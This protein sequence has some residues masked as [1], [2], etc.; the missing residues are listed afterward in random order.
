MLSE[1]ATRQMIAENPGP[2]DSLPGWVHRQLSLVESVRRKVLEV[3]S[4]EDRAEKDLLAIRAACRQ[5]LAAIQALCPH[6]ET[7][8]VGPPESHS[9]CVTCGK[10]L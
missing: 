7:S 1:Y 4:K 10:D 5:E 9:I 2:A 6:Y 3:R 8:S